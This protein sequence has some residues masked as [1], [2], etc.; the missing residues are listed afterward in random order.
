MSLN[1]KLTSKFSLKLKN[2]NKKIENQK[3]IETNSNTI[4]IL[5][6]LVSYFPRVNLYGVFRYSHF[7]DGRPL[8][9]HAFAFAP[10]HRNAKLHR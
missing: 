8:Y 6:I 2:L 10:T 5:K 1:S 9:N 7:N 3:K 4:K